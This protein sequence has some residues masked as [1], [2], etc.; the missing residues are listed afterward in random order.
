MVGGTRGRLVLE[1]FDQYY[2][3]VY[4]FARRSVDAPTAEDVAQEVF[5]RLLRIPDIENRAVSSSYLLKVADNLIKRR[6]K[7]HVRQERYVRSRPLDE[8]ACCDEGV[9]VREY[10]E[11][12][13]LGSLSDGERD[14]LR[15]IVCE[16]LSYEAAAKA[17]DVKVS[18]VNNWKFRGMRKLRGEDPSDIDSL[19]G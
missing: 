19:A 14:A 15:L 7:Q 9:F 18:T 17:L 3:R 2:E 4:W 5:V 12:D 13:S 11:P 8:C 10:S 16:G 1:L 6:H